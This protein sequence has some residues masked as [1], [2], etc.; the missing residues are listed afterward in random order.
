MSTRIRNPQAYAAAVARNGPL[1]PRAG[2]PPLRPPVYKPYRAP[3]SAGAGYRRPYVPRAVAAAPRRTYTRTAPRRVPR[4]V[5]AMS[6]AGG[7]VLATLMG[8]GTYVVNKN[9]LV[10]PTQSEQ[11]PAFGN[12]SGGTRIRHREFIQDIVGSTVFTNRNYPI[13]PGNAE[14]FPWLA[15]T[16]KNYEQYKINGMIFEFV[17]TSATALNSTNTALGTVILSTQY[18]SLAPSFTNKQQMENNV[19]TVSCKPAESVMHPIECEPSQTSVPI[20]YTYSGTL[21]PTGD[22]RL[23]NAG[24]FQLATV[25]MQADAVIGELHVTYD[26]TFYKPQLDQGLSL[27]SSTA[28]YN[29]YGI[30]VTGAGI[31]AAFPFGGEAG[32][33]PIKWFDSIGLTIDQSTGNVFLP[34]GSSGTYLFQYGV[35][36]QYTAMQDKPTLTYFNIDETESFPYFGSANPFSVSAVAAAEMAVSVIFK[37]LD[38][39]FPAYIN[40]DFAGAAVPPGV[41]NAGF[42]FVQQ[43]NGDFPAT[44]Q[45]PFPT[46]YE[47]A[48]AATSSSHAFGPPKK[49]SLKQKQPEAA[50]AHSATASS[51]SIP[52]VASEDEEKETEYMDI[53]RSP[54][55]SIPVQLQNPG[56]RRTSIP[57]N[58]STSLLGRAFGRP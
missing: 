47:S 42:I 7:S 54:P 35:I 14:V 31:T 16:A 15:S 58:P 48:A 3:A 39:N 55:A 1:P 43:M 21:P 20:L 19:F 23:Y 40:V 38:P 6:G 44:S 32:Q 27:D 11:V 29:L 12:V 52:Q 57:K 41:S 30:G 13:N 2:P 22:I 28:L 17:S 24:N 56:P 49:S 50:A 5:S 18:N 33:N 36:G 8:R 53:P 25:G 4:A 45:E 26:V 9:T 34:T 46:L 10:H 37:I 51:S